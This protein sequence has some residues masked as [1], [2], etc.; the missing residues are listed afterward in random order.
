VQVLEINTDVAELR[1]AAKAREEFVGRLIAAQ[2]GGAQAGGVPGTARRRGPDP[3]RLYLRAGS[4]TRQAARP[5]IRPDRPDQKLVSTV[6]PSVI[7]PAV[8]APRQ[9]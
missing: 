8:F 9:K 3:D 7:T 1:Q 6:P 4:L 2:E 5:E